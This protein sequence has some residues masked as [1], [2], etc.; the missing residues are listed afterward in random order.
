M[1]RNN[2]GGHNFLAKVIIEYILSSYKFDRLS[3][4]QNT[5]YPRLLHC[6]AQLVIRKVVKSQ[7]LLSNFINAR[8]GLIMAQKDNRRFAITSIA[9]FYVK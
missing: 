3:L 2:R 9:I 6:L 4:T 8:I 1:H 7:H 5:D